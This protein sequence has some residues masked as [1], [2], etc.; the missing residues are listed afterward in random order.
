ME[1]PDLELAERMKTIRKL[2]GHTLLTAASFLGVSYQQLHKYEIGE[3][4]IPAPRL[5]KL[6]DAYG[7][8]INLFFEPFAKMPEEAAP[9]TEFSLSAIQMAEAFELI[10]DKAVCTAAL[11]LIQSAAKRGNR[12]VND[13]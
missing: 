8:D 1:P 7:I 12:K 3:N 5:K 2:R 6:A 10:E 9:A 11:K 4:R 13:G